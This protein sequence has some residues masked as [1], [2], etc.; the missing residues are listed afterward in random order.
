MMKTPTIPLKTPTMVK[1]FDLKRRDLEENGRTRGERN[2]TQDI[3]DR[4][5]LPKLKLQFT[6][7]VLNVYIQEYFL[8]GGVLAQRCCKM[9]KIRHFNTPRSY[10]K[11]TLAKVFLVMH[12]S[13]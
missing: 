3:Q 6:L 2:I 12:N 9:S 10:F 4:H 5:N 7:K 11:K 8:L 13:P 1:Q